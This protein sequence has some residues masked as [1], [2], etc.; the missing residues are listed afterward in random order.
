MAVQELDRLKH[1]DALRRALA[2]P[3]S[4]ARARAIALRRLAAVEIQKPAEPRATLDGAD[5]TRATHFR[6]DEPIPDRL[7]RPLA[8]SE[9]CARWRGPRRVPGR[10]LL[11]LPTRRHRADFIP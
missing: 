1:E 11:R 10:D 7:V 2:T 8:P 9:P 3:T 5:A 6:L 4:T